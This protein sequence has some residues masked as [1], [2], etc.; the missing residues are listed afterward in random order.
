[1]DVSDA[2]DLIA[3]AIP[4]G[5]GGVWAD[6]GAGTGTFTRALQGLLGPKARI[7]A[8]DRDHGALAAL[9][10]WAASAG[11]DV[12][13]VRADFAHDFELSGLEASGLDGLL[14]ANALHFVADP[15]RVL[16][17]LVGRLVPEG[18]LVLVEYDQ[19][20]ASRWVPH[21]IPVARLP[22]LAAAAGTSPLRVVAERPS[23]Y[24]GRIYAATAVRRPASAT[25]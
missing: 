19:R 10:R 14:L 11:A 1:M 2:A 12:V 23:A 4:P 16:A 8:V 22:P 18:R 5:G 13:P 9:G 3:P 15:E 20:P 21:P 24:G 7:Y 6:L 17:R 25:S